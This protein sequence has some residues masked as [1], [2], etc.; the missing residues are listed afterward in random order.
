MR[1]TKE[2]LEAV[3][4]GESVRLNEGGTDWAIATFCQKTAPLHGL[5]W[6]QGLAF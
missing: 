4:S 2:Q 1:L 3:R 6:A 5:F